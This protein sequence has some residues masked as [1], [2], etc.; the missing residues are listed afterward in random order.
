VDPGL[1]LDQFKKAA[2]ERRLPAPAPATSSIPALERM[3]LQALLASEA[4][5]VA[6]LPRVPPPV[7][8]KFVTREIFEA[9]RRSENFTFSALE[10][11]LSPPSKALLHELVAADEIIEDTVALEQAEACLRRLETDLRKRQVDELR[12]QVK[13]AEREG[14]MDEALGIIAE[15]ERIRKDLNGAGAE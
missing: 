14:R 3:L 15:L 5:R 11:R 8:E 7:S 13:T 6:I 12:A 10:G 9:L 4:A 1:V 2:A